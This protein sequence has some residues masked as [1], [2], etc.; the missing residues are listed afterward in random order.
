MDIVSKIDVVYVIG[1]TPASWYM[2][3]IV[4]LNIEIVIRPVLK[5]FM[6]KFYCTTIIDQ[7]IWSMKILT[8]LGNFNEILALR[9]KYSA[10]FAKSLFYSTVFRESVRKFA[11]IFTLRRR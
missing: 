5:C 3:A 4:M 11:K 9:R 6:Y 7:F 2:H 1:F 8:L 10:M